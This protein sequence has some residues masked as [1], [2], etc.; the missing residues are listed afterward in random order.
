MSVN[1]GPP[2]NDP[3]SQK[4]TT[5]ISA[6][7]SAL[8]AVTSL[9]QFYRAIVGPIAPELSADLVLA[10]S[11][12][13]LANTA[14]F[15]ALLVSQ[16]PVGIAFDRFGPA[17]V[18]A[19]LMAVSAIGAFLCGVAQGRDLFLLGRLLI[20]LGMGPAFM[21]AVIML[22]AR[23]PPAR[24][25][26]ELAKVF[27]LSNLG[28][29]LA[30][31]P[32][33]VAVEYAGWRPV[34]A[35]TALLTLAVMA[36]M[37]A[38]SRTGR[39]AGASASSEALD[40]AS[41]GSAMLAILRLPGLALLLPLMATAY[42]ALITILGVWA[43]PYLSD[44]H[45]A[46]LQTRGDAQLYFAL[47]QVA[48][49]FAYGVLDRVTGRRRDLAVLGSF[50]AAVCLLAVCLFSHSLVLSVLFL[51]AFCL[52]CSFN[53]LMLSHARG[54]IPTDLAGRGVTTINLVPGI[55][56]SLLPIAFASV[57]A[58]TSVM[59]MDVQAGYQI[60]FAFIA[61]TLLVAAAIYASARTE[62][63]QSPY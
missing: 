24:L 36:A 53:V 40:L 7:V 58:V 39:E 62:P 55:G 34:H 57:L 20:G 63:P 2:P 23:L 44:V 11:D 43:G 48:G 4:P 30:S 13:A 47:A 49:V 15:G 37:F 1:Q 26:Y 31:K 52:V 10:E 18:T 54:F 29:L 28:T 45:G 33:V 9:S 14:F 46:S 3:T 35:F 19:T 32:L 21:S 42:A 8:V 50:L 56:S 25:G 51:A 17:R 59:G 38:L 41:I 12:L 5:S 27:A 61:G 6:L 16:I 22:S 60:A